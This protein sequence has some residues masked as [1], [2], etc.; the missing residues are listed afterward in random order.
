MAKIITD[1]TRALLIRQSVLF[2]FGFELND[3]EKSPPC[4]SV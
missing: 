3:Y 4:K 1:I 2:H